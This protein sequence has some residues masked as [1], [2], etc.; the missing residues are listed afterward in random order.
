MYI[1][2]RLKLGHEAFKSTWILSK[3]FMCRPTDKQDPNEGCKSK[4]PTGKR[5]EGD[6]KHLGTRRRIKADREKM[7]ASPVN[8]QS[9][10]ASPLS[11]PSCPETRNAGAFHK[12]RQH[13][14]V[15]ITPWQTNKPN[16]SQ[17]NVFPLK[18]FMFLLFYLARF[19]LVLS[20]VLWSCSWQLSL[21]TS[22]V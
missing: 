13:V 18:A 2:S 16:P 15:L 12:R 19:R 10:C 6:H 22:S 11:G 17:H 7:R 5:P 4:W 3:E 21:F 9:Q 20:A 14:F 1:F 8:T